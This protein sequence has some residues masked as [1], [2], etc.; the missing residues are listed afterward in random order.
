MSIKKIRT[1]HISH[2]CCVLTAHFVYESFSERVSMHARVAIGLLV[3]VVVL[4]I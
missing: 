1:A 2:M 3:V 4:R